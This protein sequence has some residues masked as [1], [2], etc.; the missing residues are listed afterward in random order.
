[1]VFTKHLF[2]SVANDCQ[3]FSIL[4]G[5]SFVHEALLDHAAPATVADEVEPQPGLWGDRLLA[6]L[7]V[8]SNALGVAAILEIGQVAGLGQEVK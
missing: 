8:H 2:M 5:T 3:Q 1:M 7:V 4:M 6:P